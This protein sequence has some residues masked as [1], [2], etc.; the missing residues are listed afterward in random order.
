MQRRRDDDRRVLRQFSQRDAIRAF[1]HTAA[2]REVRRN[3]E[4][5][6]GGDLRNAALSQPIQN[7][8]NQF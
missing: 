7:R 4:S 8:V 2:R 1:Y 6:C 5:H 3:P